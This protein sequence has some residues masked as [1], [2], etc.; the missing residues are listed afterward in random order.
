MW[1]RGDRRGPI[2]LFIPRNQ[3]FRAPKLLLQRPLLGVSSVG[4]SCACRGRLHVP[5]S[6]IG[7]WKASRMAHRTGQLENPKAPGA[8]G[9]G[10]LRQLDGFA[11]GLH[12]LA[13]GTR[14]KLLKTVT[15]PLSFRLSLL[16]FSIT[17]ERF[18]S[19]YSC[20]LDSLLLG[21]VPFFFFLIHT[22]YLLAC[23][24]AEE[25]HIPFPKKAFASLR[26][27]RIVRVLPA[28]LY[29]RGETYSIVVVVVVIVTIVAID[30]F[31]SVLLVLL[32]GDDVGNFLFGRFLLHPSSSTK[33]NFTSSKVE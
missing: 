4:F 27:N 16:L 22:P 24:T 20:S 14:K 5:T 18:D 8:C 30:M 26:P 3:E 11:M 10:R 25:H 33:T 9:T 32:V 12:I 23:G 21:P 15:P 2:P 1:L 28:E 31:R 7:E 19:I 13:G 6:W 29:L 17:L